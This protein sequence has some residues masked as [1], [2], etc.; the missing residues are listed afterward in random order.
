MLDTIYRATQ[1]YKPYPQFGTITHYSN[2]GH[3]SYHGATFRLERHY[4]G[5]MT[6]NT[7]YTWSKA[8]NDADEE[9]AARGVS[10]YNRALEKGVANFD[11]RHRF[12]ATFTYD[13]PFGKGRKFL[14]SGGWKDAVLGG[15]LLMWSHSAQSGLPLTVTYASSPNRYL[16]GVARPDILVPF[17]QAR[18]Q[19]WNIGANRFPTSAQNAYLNMSA[20][21][22]PAS[23]KAGTLGA[24]HVPRPLAALAAGLAEQGM[25]HSGTLPLHPPL[26]REQRSQAAP[27]RPAR[28]GVRHAQPR[29]FR[30]LL[31]HHGQSVEHR[32]PVPL[33]A[34]TAAGLVSQPVGGRRNV[35]VRTAR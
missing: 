28:H 22:Y 7:F 23:Y 26:G 16:P 5:G 32:Q 15:W 35:L 4:S 1:N 30:P 27:V 20:F 12:V 29:Q 10:F 19:D 21:A 11:L 34:W 9:G 24:Q 3:S 33:G 18:V 13:L 6:L 31:G 8:L 14:N 2:Y 25:G 17:D